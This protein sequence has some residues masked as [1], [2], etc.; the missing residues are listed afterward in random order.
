MK[1]IFKCS[2]ALL[3]FA[4]V[5]ACTPQSSVGNTNG[6]TVPSQ[7]PET[8]TN[9]S[10]IK[11][12]TEVATVPQVEGFT[13]DELFD[14][15]GGGCGMSLWKSGSNP[16]ETILFFN[17]TEANSTLMKINGEFVKFQRTEATGE[18]FYGQK[19]SQMFISEDGEIEVTVDVEL[20]EKGEIESVGIP[21]GT[22]QIEQAGE[23]VE[24]P[25]VGDA[26]C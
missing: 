9:S 21:Q 22:L 4:S 7:T 13:M 15:G 10:N 17:G 20:G 23:T 11:P 18:D 19:N 6:E 16:P 5:S 14:N 25:V 1:T 3:L 26:G 12:V 2:L 24:I 8:E